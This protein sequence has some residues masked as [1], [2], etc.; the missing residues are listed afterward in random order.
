MVIWVQVVCSGPARRSTVG[1]VSSTAVTLTSALRST[2]RSVAVSVAL[3]SALSTACA[4]S[5]TPQAGDVGGSS[6]TSLSERPTVT[7]PRPSTAPPAV[8]DRW[9]ET[10][11]ASWYGPGFA[12]RA[13]ANGETF[14]PNL[15][16]AAHPTLPFDTRVRVTL[17]A[18]G[19]SVVVRIN[20][21]GPFARGRIID[22]SRAAADQIGLV[23]IGVGDVRLTLAGGPA[24]LRDVR[25][26]DRL[27]GYDVVVP[28]A[29]AGRL[30]VLRSSEGVDVVVR[31]VLLDPSPIDTSDDGTEIW[32]S[33]GLAERLGGAA[34]VVDESLA[35]S[36]ADATPP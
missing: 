3:A 1:G 28:G 14:D 13:T 11:E 27:V 32:T 34:T 10:G 9:T 25:V 12:G 17:V 22:L 18:T 15:L 2:V 19:Q 6:D 7:M 5:A 23:A 8:P 30:M 29:P 21:R 4:P 31:A 36:L 20:D 35:P 24:G 33:A 26:D 16:T